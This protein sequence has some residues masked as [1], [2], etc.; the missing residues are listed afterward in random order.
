MKA[1]DVLEHEHEIILKVVEAA[2]KEAGR[3]RERG[4]LQG[5]VAAQLVDFFRNFADKCHHAKEERHLFAKMSEKGMSREAGPIAVMLKEHDEGRSLVREIAE[6]LPRAG[7]GDA[8]SISL[9]SRNL[10]AYAELLRAHIDKENTV[11]YPLALKMTS[12]AEQ[13]EL[14]KAFEKLEEQEMGAGVH[15]K[16]H[17]LAHK[18]AGE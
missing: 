2:E 14:L 9:I 12:A 5:D 11:L 15:E 6:A 4:E 10:R 7:E 18:L 3:I 8:E 16:Y 13:R 17:E 1:T